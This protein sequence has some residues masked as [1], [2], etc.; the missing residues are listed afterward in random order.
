MIDNMTGR[1]FRRFS[2]TI[3]ISA[4]L[5]LTACTQD[6][7]RMD[8]PRAVKG[9]LDLSGWDFS[10]DGPV[11]LSGEW[12]FYWGKLL[13]AR[14]LATG[15]YQDEK[16]FIWVP[17]IWNGHEVNGRKIS[18][19]G[20]ATYRLKVLVRRHKGT[21]AFKFLSMGTAFRIYVNGQEVSSDGVVGTTPETMVPEWN[22]H[23]ASFKPQG[24]NLE[25]ILHVS[26]FY[27]R[28]GGAVGVIKL[29]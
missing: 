19:S 22:P 6:S 20:Y 8:M 13:N 1:L 12:E 27:H 9:Q 17:G 29:G 25:I 21:M 15:K 24:D 3:F 11:N 4:L 5:I 10:T 14:D 7:P 23:V 18:G 28:K 26:N 16:T 2:Y